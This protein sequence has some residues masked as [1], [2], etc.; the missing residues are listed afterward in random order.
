MP[1][2]CGVD[3][4]ARQQTICYCDTADGVPHRR[5]LDHQK[6]DVRS[7]Y[8]QLT[9]KVIV[10]LEASGYSTWF[11]E[12]LEGLGHQALIGNATEIRRVARRR[13]NLPDL[14]AEMAHDLP[15]G[16]G[17]MIASAFLWPVLDDAMGMRREP[18]GRAALSH[19]SAG[20]FA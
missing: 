20:P 10:G 11:I 13:H 17:C 8:S 6:D 2:Y 7:F 18:E 3:F 5:E 4:H 19:L 12:L 1:I 9:G 16:Q 14:L 15:C